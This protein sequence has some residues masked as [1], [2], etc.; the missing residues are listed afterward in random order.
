M[1]NFTVD[2]FMDKGNFDSTP[3]YYQN[4]DISGDV[5]MPVSS[6]DCFNGTGTN[7]AYNNKDAA[8]KTYR[9]VDLKLSTSN[10]ES[11]GLTLAWDI[12]ENLEIKSL[13]GYR[14]LGWHAYQDYAEAFSPTTS[15]P[16]YYTTDDEVNSHQFSQEFIFTGNV[17]DNRIKYTGGLYYFFRISRNSWRRRPHPT[18]I[19]IVGRPRMPSRKP[20]MRKPLTPPRY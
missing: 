4:A 20:F 5:C 19:K 16:V 15:F 10:F 18:L 6:I 12:N 8:D 17:L 9:P 3:S 11:H 2:Y 13:T 7:Y 1:D 14:E